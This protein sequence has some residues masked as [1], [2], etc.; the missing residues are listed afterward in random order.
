MDDP[1]PH[2]GAVRQQ[3]LASLSRF[4]ANSIPSAADV[5]V[6]ADT[7][8]LGSGPFDSLAILQ[9]VMFVADE[10]GV[11]VGDEDFTEDNF[12]TPGAIAGFVA[13]RLGSKP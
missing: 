6:D 1:Y 8:L 9:I 11:E 3:V 5:S 7:P 10:Y 2:D 4:I 12:A 13:A